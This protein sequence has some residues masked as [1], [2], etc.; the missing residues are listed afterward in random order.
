MRT[1]V[2]Y[3]HPDA[4]SFVAAVKDRAVEALRAAGHNVR[5][6]DL[7]AEGFDPLFSAAERARHLEVGADRTVTR[8]VVDLQWCQQLV[9]VY[10]TWWSGQPAMLKGWIE[11]VWVRGATWDLPVGGNRIRG[12][13]R[14]VRRIVAI[15]THGSSKLV[16]AVQG[17][18]GKRIVTRTLRAVCHPLARTRWIAMYGVDVASDEDRHAF[19]VRISRQL[20]R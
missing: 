7:Y 2:V 13:L 20:G 15:T 4:E 3:C 10:P 5:V 8:H 19:L 14:N 11:R 12:R 9:L 16:N 6:T 18:P 17:E 1:L